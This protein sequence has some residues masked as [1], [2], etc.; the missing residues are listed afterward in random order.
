MRIST[1]LLSAM[2]AGAVGFAG[3]P[4]PAFSAGLLELIG[5]SPA[6]S[7]L[8]IS[9]EAVYPGVS[10]QVVADTVAAPIEQQ[11]NGVEKMRYM[12]SRCNND[13]TYTLHV[14]FPEDAD[15]NMMQILVQNRVAL[16][17]PLLP[18]AVQQ[19]GI[20]V[21]KKSPGAILIV[22]LRSPDGSRNVRDLSNE[23]AVRLKD[24]L[25]RLPGTGDV[26]CIGCVD[27]AARVKLD[28]E[29]MAAG[30]L[31]AGDV[32]AALRQQNA[33]AA[34]GQ[35]GQ[36]ATPP[37]KG[38]QIAITGPRLSDP[39]QLREIVLRADAGGRVVRLKDVAGV[40]AETGAQGSQALLDGKPVVALA[41][42]LLPGARPQEVSAAVGAELA[43]LRP[44]LAKG[45]DADASFD[46][47]SKPGPADRPAPAQYLLLDLVVPGGASAERTRK[48]LTR[49]QTL[50]RDVAGVQDLL[51]LSEN[52]IDAFPAR[53]CLV[54]R[55]APAGK[56][57]PGR[58]KVV[59]TIRAR[60]AS[61]AEATVRLRDL[62]APGGF[63]RGGY[64]VAM[65]IADRGLEQKH[66][67]ELAG[68]LA[69]RL[70]ETKKLTDVW[71]DSELASPQVFVDVDRAKAARQGVSLNDV[72]STLQVAGGGLFVN[73]PERFGQ[74][75]QVR[76]ESDVKKPAD[77]GKLRVR[78]AAGQMVPLSAIMSVRT[79][80]GPAF[81]DRFN[82]YPIVEV[83]ANP[84]AG[85]SLDQIHAICEAL[86][87]AVRKELGLSE[88]FRLT[89]L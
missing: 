70:R 15:A 58:E 35:T 1:G 85:V 81:V 6:K 40:E 19:R 50:L 25:A 45:V 57:S 23:A 11:V 51:A 36:P 59:E 22:I 60:L 10:A 56:T 80:T 61:M 41:V 16:A 34:A 54:V 55:L 87:G 73:D 63:R 14:V 64:P 68:K 88:E 71:A 79:T 2:L 5:I 26:T 76:I 28:A 12:R 39:E 33:Q 52:P 67:G 24:E 74:T 75:S 82:M 31:T 78:S 72:F 3:A 53:P 66:L 83:S 44:G 47:T 38:F 69:K 27:C 20:T 21:R 9:V 4:P 13:G 42:C 48:A 29:K 43:E 30:N 37:R 62:S 84:A 7:P 65:A 8:V 77:I 17:L 18:D 32:V 89:W 86:F 46:F 49:C